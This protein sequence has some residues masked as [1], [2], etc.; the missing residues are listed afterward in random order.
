MR[1]ER[2]IVVARPQ[3]EVFAFV[4]N[5]ENL[6]SWQQ[7]VVEVR[8]NGPLE[9]GARYTEVRTFLGKRFES[10]VEVHGPRAAYHLCAAGSEGPYPDQRPAHVRA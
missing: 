7:E 8:L 2:S 4:V 9:A 3:E 6:S 10:T 5:L 1:V